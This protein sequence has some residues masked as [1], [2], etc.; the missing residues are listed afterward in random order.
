MWF[1]VLLG[2]VAIMTVYTVISADKESF[3]AEKKGKVRDLVDLLIEGISIEE[4]KEIVAKF[5]GVSE[6]ILKSMDENQELYISNFNWESGSWQYKGEIKLRFE[7][8]CLK[9]REICLL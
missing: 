8:N 1:L 2:V 3:Y 5:K 9:S 7:N 4:T 6:P